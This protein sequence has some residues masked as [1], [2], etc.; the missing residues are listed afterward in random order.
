[1]R[2]RLEFI[3][4]DLGLPA[5]DG[6]EVARRLR[7]EAACRETVVLAVTGYGQAE[8][9]QRS[10]AAGIDHHLLKPVDP[11]ALL[12]LLSRPEAV[13]S[14]EGCSPGCA[15]APMSAASPGRD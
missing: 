1:L 4:L 2:W 7:Q 3:L 11:A 9:R 14:A 6:Y 12:A 8:A 10:R 15:D 13:S 5:M